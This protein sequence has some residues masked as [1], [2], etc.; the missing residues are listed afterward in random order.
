[1]RKKI[2]QTFSPKKS[3]FSHFIKKTIFLIFISASTIT[4]AQVPGFE[5]D[6]NDETEPVAPID[7]GTMML[8]CLGA[9]FGIYFI[10]KNQKLDSRSQTLD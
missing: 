8:S 5:D 9:V 1:M 4:F 10:R 7:S 3:L 6:V 2:S